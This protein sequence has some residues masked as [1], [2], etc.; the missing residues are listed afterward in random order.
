MV[1]GPNASQYLRA[2]PVPTFELVDPLDFPST[3]FGTH[4]EFEHL[5]NAKALAMGR[6]VA[7]RPSFAVSTRRSRSTG[8]THLKSDHYV[9]PHEKYGL[10]GNDGKQ[11][12]YEVIPTEP[13]QR[14]K[15]AWETAPQ[16][17]L[18]IP[19][20]AA[21]LHFASRRVPSV[22]LHDHGPRRARFPLDDGAVQPDSPRGETQSRRHT[23][24][25][26]F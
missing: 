4:R 22:R 18:Q 11:C 23:Q 8:G 25:G 2:A 13:M 3:G 21:R 24:R 6:W 14:W 5:H 1:Q 12:V 7:I 19:R 10:A 26:G 15:V 16:G 9:F 20:F 17:R